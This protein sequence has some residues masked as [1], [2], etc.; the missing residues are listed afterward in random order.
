MHKLLHVKIFFLFLKIRTLCS[1]VLSLTQQKIAVPL[2]QLSKRV[3][4]IGN[5]FWLLGGIKQA[6]L[7][8]AASHAAQFN[9]RG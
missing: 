7:K 3:R 8:Q 4:F 2:Y 9:L 1:H 5:C 6:T